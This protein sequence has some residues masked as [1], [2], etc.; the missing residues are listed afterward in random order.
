MMSEDIVDLRKVQASWNTAQNALSCQ[1]SVDLI[2]TA[3]KLIRFLGLVD[4]TLALRKRVVLTR[5]A[6][7]YW[8]N[9]LPL[10]SKFQSNGF[11]HDVHTENGACLVPPLDCA[12]IWHCHKL[13]PVRYASDCKR[14][15][16]KLIDITSTTRKES[17]PSDSERA[18]SDWWRTEYPEEPYHLVQ[19]LEDGT[20]T[21]FQNLLRLTPKRNS[22]TF[23][24]S[25]DFVAAAARQALFYYQVRR[26]W[27]TEDGFLE[28]ALQRYKGYLYM[29]QQ[30]LK[31]RKENGPPVFLVPTYDIDLMWHSH[32][33]H[34]SAY[35]RD[36][37][38]LIGRLLDHDD[39]D[40]D[41]SVGKKLHNGFLETCNR[42]WA[43]F[44]TVYERAGSMY[45]GPEPRDAL[46][47]GP[48]EDINAIKKVHKFVELAS[49]DKLGSPSFES[50][51]LSAFESDPEADLRSTIHVLLVIFGAQ[52]V[53]DDHS[54][55]RYKEEY[56]VRVTA[57]AKCPLLCLN[58]ASK[59]PSVD[60]HVVWNH[61]YA[62]ECELATRGLHLE[63]I[64]TKKRK[65]LSTDFYS[66][67]GPPTTSQGYGSQQSGIA[68][69]K[70]D[71]VKSGDESMG[72]VCILWSDLDLYS[73]I[74]GHSSTKT[75]VLST[76]LELQFSISVTPSQR[77]P[78]L[79]R[80]LLSP[81]TDDHCNNIIL[82]LAE[83]ESL[84]SGR[85]TTKTVVNHNGIPTYIIRSRSEHSL[86]QD[87]TGWLGRNW[88]ET[89]INLHQAVN[90]PGPSETQ[91]PRTIHA[92]AGEVIGTAKLLVNIY[93]KLKRNLCR[94]WSIFDGGAVLTVNKPSSL[95]QK[96][97]DC[98]L[99]GD[100][101]PHPMMLLSGRRLEYSI[102]DGDCVSQ[103]LTL[104][105]C[106]TDAPKGQASALLNLT[107]ASFEVMPGESSAF[108]LLIASAVSMSLH[109]FG[110]PIDKTI[111]WNAR[112]RDAA[113]VAGI[114]D[115]QLGAIRLQRNQFSRKWSPEQNCLIA[116]P[117]PK[118]VR[119]LYLPWWQLDCGH[120]KFR[121]H[122]NGA[123]CQ[124][125]ACAGA[126]CGGNVQRQTTTYLAA[127]DAGAQNVGYDPAVVADIP[128]DGDDDCGC[129]GGG[130]DGGDGGSGCGGGCGGGCG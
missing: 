68:K 124:P 114:S 29:I 23:T 54:R 103:Y 40:S 1:P 112:A 66:F 2:A 76:G 101:G 111:R 27:F 93:S 30:S 50:H 4:N 130:G 85:W 70:Q 28:V 55:S 80:S 51:M 69:S 20:S 19:P 44:G 56:R 63:V 58:T 104:A 91:S 94:Q 88:E 61:G 49:G 59:K 122:F 33:L 120:W 43:T 34:P 7:R 125:A 15:F 37:T 73:S 16:G 53:S 13:S 3:K 96:E 109:A 87:S 18:S 108:V 100:W 127:D 60:N 99:H 128:Y 17:I 10:A 78:K 35:T 117:I 95:R 121:Q 5:A 9:W 62:M 14:L 24:Q 89:T 81:V 36:T 42:W 86:S 113:L 47:P 74:P 119:A 32:Q 116:K 98:E 31:A 115:G 39:S 83:N 77:A 71:A 84:Q 110:H 52:N 22:S 102:G 75:K 11:P 123:Q 129:T 97:I 25:Y 126:A 8:N 82:R 90:T 26:S 92:T 106:T 12:W 57:V 105:R 65:A 64:C 41:R 118:T 48:K 6:D 79:F 45:R 46:L 21:E 38:A 72:T 67:L 107:T